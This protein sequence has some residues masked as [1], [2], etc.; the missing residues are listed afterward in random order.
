MLAVGNGDLWMLSTP[1]GK[2]GFFHDV[3]THGEGWEKVMAT[4]PE[5]ARIPAKF[6]E[7]VRRDMGHA[8]F[9]QEYMGEFVTS[10]ANV[11]D[12]DKVEAMF[13]ELEESLLPEGMSVWQ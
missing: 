1:W 8:W 12:R 10:G 6:L 5:C 7:Q 3:W 11:F 9:R 2:R 13:D 4:G